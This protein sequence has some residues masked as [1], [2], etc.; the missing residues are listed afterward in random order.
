MCSSSKWLSSNCIRP[1]CTGRKWKTL[2]WNSSAV[3]QHI[4][5]AVFVETVY[6]KTNGNLV[7][8]K[9]TIVWDQRTSKGIVLIQGIHRMIFFV[10][11]N[12]GID[13]ILRVKTKKQKS[14]ILSWN[15]SFIRR[16]DFGTWNSASSADYEEHH[17]SISV[18]TLAIYST[19]TMDVSKNQWPLWLTGV[20]SN[21]IMDK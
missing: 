9:Q 14:N 10:S 8:T 6:C 4:T 3:S 19:I 16:N 7:V 20:N 11:D 1:I 13:N 5:T 15:K 21:L 17:A 18:Y 2:R 12:C